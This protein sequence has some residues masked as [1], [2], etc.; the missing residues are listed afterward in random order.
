MML[1]VEYNGI[2]GSSLGLIVKERPSI[3]AAV[4]KADEIEIPGRSGVVRTEKDEFEE[5]KFTIDFN[6]IGRSEDWYERWRMAQEW[7]SAP[8]KKL[9]LSDDPEYFFLVTKIELSEAERTTERIGNFSATVRTKDGLHY[10][11]TGALECAP[12]KIKRN[13]YETAH[14]IYKITGTGTCVITVNG[15]SVM[16]DVDQELTI[17]TERKLAY[18]NKKMKNTALTGDYEDLYFRK[19]KIEVS[20]T[21][22]FEAKIIPNWR[23]M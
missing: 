22:G 18:Q 5:S 1:D 11:R 14:P 9:I 3:P 7:L 16:A 17:D 15:K 21:D 20:I 2:R 8:N 6:Y 19:G 10:L 4:K 13:V 23:R 12:E